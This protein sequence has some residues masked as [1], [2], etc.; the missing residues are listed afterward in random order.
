MLPLGVA[1]GF[2]EGCS[3]RRAEPQAALETRAPGD[4]PPAQPGHPRPGP[5]VCPAGPANPRRLARAWGEKKINKSK[6][7]PSPLAVLPLLPGR[8]PL[9]EKR[10]LHGRRRGEEG[11]HSAGPGPAWGGAL[12]WVSDRRSSRCNDCPPRGWSHGAGFGER[13]RSSASGERNERFNLGF[14]TTRKIR[15]KVGEAPD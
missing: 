3:R 2:T 6:P 14:Q 1:A 9:A 12:L 13:L 8:Q 10:R 4:A 11:N 7:T 15:S 5:D